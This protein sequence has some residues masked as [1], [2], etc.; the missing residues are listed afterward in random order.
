MKSLFF[1][2]SLLPLTGQLSAATIS[3]ST[4][5]GTL[6]ADT[7][8]RSDQ[9]TTNFGTANQLIVGSNNLFGNNDGTG[10]DQ[11]PYS[12][13]LRFDLSDLQTAAGGQPVVI[14][15]VTL[16]V[17]T[18]TVGSGAGG[19]V[20]FDLALFDYAFAFGEATATHNNPA[21]NGSDST[22]GGATGTLLTALT[23]TSAAGGQT[24][25]FA[26]SSQ[27]VAN[28]QSAYT[29][30]GNSTVNYILKETTFTDNAGFIR[31]DSRDGTPVGGFAPTLT[32]DYSVV[33]EPSVA[34]LGGLGLLGFLRR[35]RA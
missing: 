14:N 15:S 35:R 18:T 9:P 17:H 2:V 32:I 25:T 16:M 23:I 6:G 24:W 4:A 19:S 1:F 30:I 34:L 31:L 21:G 11:A 10:T 28:L 20:P 26:S 13:L 7:Y 22:I 29:T 5:S 3:I 33:P 27:F 12:G 8:L